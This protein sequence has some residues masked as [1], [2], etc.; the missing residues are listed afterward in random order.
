MERKG[1]DRLIE[2]TKVLLHMSYVQGADNSGVPEQQPPVEGQARP[3]SSNNDFVGIYEIVIFN[4]SK[5]KIESLSIKESFMGLLT[6]SLSSNYMNDPNDPD[7]W[8]TGELRP[9]LTNVFVECAD[10]TIKCNS[11]NDIMITKG[12]L[13][14]SGSILPN[15]VC[16]LIVRMAG[17]GKLAL[18]EP[19]SAS[20]QLPDNGYSSRY[21]R[22]A[23]VFMSNSA[24]IRGFFACICGCNRKAFKPLYIKDRGFAPQSL[25][26]TQ[27]DVPPTLPLPF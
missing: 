13:I 23:P 4:N 19:T 14:K 27:L 1:N 9:H 12:E 7:V 20:G 15:G 26:L 10:S 18:L 3:I 24:I 8:Y 2:A 11:F 25:Q 21:I 16:S 17:R 6:S 5:Y 22:A